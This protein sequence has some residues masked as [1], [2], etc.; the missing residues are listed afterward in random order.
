MRFPRLQR[1]IKL[2][3]YL[4][5]TML[6]W[7]IGAQAGDS[8]NNQ[9]IQL[10]N[11][12]YF[13][14]FSGDQVLLQPRRYEIKPMADS[15]QVISEE[16]ASPIQLA[17]T[18][19]A[20]DQDLSE[21]MA[22]SVPGIP[23]GDSADLHVLALFL[24]GGLVYEA[25][26]TY[27]GIRPRAVDPQAL[28][29]DPMEIYLEKLVHFPD[30]DGNVLE[31]GPGAYTVEGAEER[32]RLL[33]PEQDGGFVLEARQENNDEALDAAV[34]LSLPGDA[35]TE[36]DLHYIVLMNPTGETLQASG[37]YSG[38]HPR[39]FFQNIGKGAR[40]TVTRA[41]GTVSR[42]GQG[43]RRTTQ[44]IGKGVLKGAQDARQLAQKAALEAKKKA[45]WIARQAAQGA[46]I[47]AK[48]ACKAGLTATRI[49]A[50]VQA[51]ILGPIIGELAK[52]LQAD[53]AQ[54]ALRQAINTIK[55]QQGPAIQ[56]AINAGLTLTDPKNLK[57]VNQLMAPNRMCEQ[58]ASTVQN[59]FQK[60]VGAPLRAALTESQNADTS[61][62]R[63]RGSVA[64]A[65]IGIGGNLAKVGG[66]ELGVSHAFDFVNT[67]HWYL[68]L[69]A[70]VKTNVGGGGG[71]SIGIFPKVNPDTV[72][73]WFLGAGVGF[74][75]PHPKL[76]KV[77]D[78]GLDVF[79][80][81]P[82]RIEPPFRPQ[83]DLTSAKFFLDHF[84]GFA[85]GVGAGKSVSPVDI[86]LKA[87]V[88]I[89]LTKP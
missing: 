23:D 60:M 41:K 49:A 63:S 25:E 79:F 75:F 68:D 5:A 8:L 74:P 15:L 47:A 59:T 86:A 16:G 39:G 13:T 43:A 10:E 73:G 18:L 57:T 33:T 52:A 77:M 71:I 45:E 82:L 69:A 19:D 70:M 32:I 78:A 2:V 72:G 54:A 29:T 40:R 7:N 24:P 35:E 6:F 36:A 34:A 42:I 46:L 84:Q 30:S 37:T 88:G 80:D 4:T 48:A 67:S 14:T 66:G 64:S 26:G 56:Q 11:P 1:S 81:F 51:K 38:I 21:P 17:I 22:V 28:I 76:A 89:R 53:K 58:P 20:H 62:V 50:E 87:G 85:V 9:S 44:Q 12:A 27:S 61:Q 31:V 83:W 3:I 65:S 55:Q